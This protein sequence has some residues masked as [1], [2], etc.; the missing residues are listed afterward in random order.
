[1]KQAIL[2]AIICVFGASG[3]FAQDADIRATI[4]QQFEAFKADDFATAF[5]FASPD[6]QLFFQ[7]PQNFGQMVSQGY[8][9]VWRPAAVAYLELREEDGVYFQKVQIADQSGMFHYLEYHMVQ[10]DGAW[11]IGGVQILDA[12]GAAV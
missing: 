10:L 5:A 9:M 11:R 7:S 3:V 1:M 2:A 8:P 6:L 12:P 4:G